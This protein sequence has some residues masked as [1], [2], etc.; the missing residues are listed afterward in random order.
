MA[1]KEVGIDWKDRRLIEG[2]YLSQTSMIKFNGDLSDIAIIG[3]CVHQG[4][5]ISPILFTLYVEKIMV[6]AFEDCDLGI[7]VGGNRTRDISFSGDQ[8]MIANNEAELQRIIDRLNTTANKFNMNINVGKTKVMVASKTPKRAKIL[9]DQ[10]RVEQL[11]R[12][13]YLG[14]VI[15]E[16]GST[17]EDTKA[18]IAMARKKFIGKREILSSEMGYDLRKRLIK[19]LIW[20][21][22][23][24]GAKR[25]HCPKI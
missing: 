5:L 1:I 16:D 21:V 13:V 8:A 4:C 22:A 17:I 18:R 11:R 15:T 2:L 7:R 25:G 23:T 3:Q 14:S 10:E 20:S 6:E 24:D 9:I 19:C 12:F